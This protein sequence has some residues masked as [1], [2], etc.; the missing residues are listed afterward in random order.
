MTVAD[1]R[2]HGAAVDWIVEASEG[3]ASAPGETRLHHL[4]AAMTRYLET[5]GV[6]LSIGDQREVLAEALRR[7][8]AT[9]QPG[10]GD[11]PATPRAGGTHLQDTADILMEALSERLDY[12]RFAA[13]PADEQRQAVRSLVR[14]LS[15][16][17]RLQLNADELGIVLNFAMDD[18]LGLGPIQPLLEDRSI[19]DI[20]VNGP[21]RVYVERD[22]KV[23][24]SDV[25]FRDDAHVIKIA[26]RIVGAVG[27]RIDES[28]PMIDARLKDGSRVNVVIPPLAIDGP[29]ITI[30]KFPDRPMRLETLV[31][32]GSLSRKM[33]DFFGLAAEL[34]LNILV[35]GGTGSGK[36]TLLNAMS[37]RIPAQERIITLED[38]AELQLQKP[39][40]VRF[41]TRPPN[42]EGKGEITM[43]TLMRNALRMRPDRIVIGEIRGDEVLDLLQAMN[44][45]HD[46]SMSTLHANSPREALVRIEGLAALAGT[47]LST[48][49]VRA[50]LSHALHLVVQV[51]RMRDGHRRVISICE[52]TGAE[53]GVL[54]LQE[55]FGFRVSPHSTRNRVD[56]QFVC[57]GYRPK[58]SARAAEFGL[59]EDLDDVLKD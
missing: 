28:Q 13:L 14:D 49:A 41:E 42:V 16:E 57:T 59:G 48:E 43:R 31:K 7:C 2:I 33:A 38:A 20:M 1:K 34:R 56:G 58:F 53:G 12:A 9:P 55:I 32:M 27:R 30:R 21:D 8:G 24:L 46:G 6:A 29:T 50:Q 10:W 5:A 18:V 37:E 4:N 22:G 25:R 26:S 39:H 52:V 17:A 35:S 51:A 45:G 54:T 19:S 40:I 36:T 11:A 15:V 47:Q 3:A 23:S 44:T